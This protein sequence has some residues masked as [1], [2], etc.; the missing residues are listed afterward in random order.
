MAAKFTGKSTNPKRKGWPDVARGPGRHRSIALEKPKNIRRTFAKTWEYLSAYKLQLFFVCLTI[1]G[2]SAAPVAGTYLLKPL[3]NTILELLKVPNPDLSGFISL[4]LLLSAI[5]LGGVLCTYLYNRLMLDIS[6]GILRKIR[7]D[8]FTHMQNLPLQFFDKHTHGEIMSRYIND[9]DTLREMLARGI[10]N[11]ISS[12]FTV[13][14]VFIMMLVLS[15]LLTVL[16]LG[17]LAVMLATVSRIGRKSA[18][19]FIKQQRALGKL[20]GY[21]EEMLEGQK[22]VQVFSREETVKTDF[23]KLNEELFD[24]TSSAHTF[25]NILMPIMGNLSYVHYAVTALAGAALA[26]RGQLDLGTV[27]S[28]LQYTRSFSHPITQI[29]QQFNVVLSAMAGAERIFELLDEPVEEDFGDVT[30]VNA[31]FNSSG[32]LCEVPHRTGIWAWKIPTEGGAVY[33][34]V[35]GDVR[36]LD[37]S[38]GYQEDKPVLEGINLYAKPGQKIALVGSTGAGKTTITNLINRFYDIKEGQILY[39]GIDLKRIKK[40]DLRRSLGMVLQDTHLFTGTVMENIRYGNLEA[41]DEEVI[42]AAKL[43]NAH[44]F[45]KHLP[46][47]YNTVLTADGANLSQGQRQLIAIARAAVADPP[48]LILDEATSSI[49]TRTEALIQRGMDTLM[50]GRTV[51]VIAHRLSTVRNSN[52]IMVLEKGRIIERGDHEELLEQRGKYYQLYTG[53]FELS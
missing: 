8:M 16:V 12:A 4:L 19:Y 26:I 28:F 33:R 15:P 13:T 22:E 47:G 6:T 24:A 3:I 48:V 32:E 45:I 46:Q 2:S 18:N 9:V 31:E 40:A 7:I 5:Y 53:A 43:A 44:S 51:F 35:K 34:Q 14:S 42:E 30:L 37:V 11:L 50:E 38:F 20:N 36:F 52:A 21:V 39:D 29:S 41:T 27:G 23:D 49:D 10:P 25:A 17:M 1:L